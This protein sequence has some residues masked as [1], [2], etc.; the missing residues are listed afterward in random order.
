M[1][2]ELAHAGAEHLDEGF[3]AGYDRKQGEVPDVAAV[4]DLALLRANGIGSDATVVDLGAGTG[5]FAAV[6]AP[7]VGRVVAVD[8]SPVMLRTLRDRLTTLDAA[9]SAR[10]EVVQAGLLTYTHEGA[11]AD[12]VHIRN[13]LH[14]LPDVFKALALHRVAGMLRRGGLLRLHDLVYDT[15]P[16]RFEDDLEAWFAGAADD[17]DRGYT[18]RDLAE[19]VRTEHSTFT[20][21]LEP[22]LDRTG[23][24]V[25]DRSVR[26]GVYA[27]YTC[28]RR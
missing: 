19:H 25:V 1:L 5:R 24:E 23:F 21:L 3:V 16:D 27:S 13:A 26:R 14:Q 12:V 7:H 28:A 11:A 17:P 9:A 18:R 15:D 6:V 20:W 8:V 4:E 22:M 2:D 10:V